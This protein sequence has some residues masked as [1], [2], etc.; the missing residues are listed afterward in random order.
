VMDK[1]LIPSDDPWQRAFTI[2]L[3]WKSK[4]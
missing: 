4:S 2:S 3:L 1:Y